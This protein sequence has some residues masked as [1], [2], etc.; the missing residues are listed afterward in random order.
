MFVYASAGGG[1]RRMNRHYFVSLP[2][3]GSR[4]RRGDRPCL[5]VPYLFPY[6]RKQVCPVILGMNPASHL[7]AGSE[8]PGGAG[9]GKRLFSGSKHMGFL[10]LPCVVN[11]RKLVLRW[12]ERV[13]CLTCARSTRA[14]WVWCMSELL[15]L[16]TRG[17]VRTLERLT[18]L[19]TRLSSS[20]S[21]RID[22]SD[23]NLPLD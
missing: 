3:I 15:S 18:G 17:L 21:V 23:W 12:S 6:G 7:G 10:R 20:V 11:W 22:L 1:G 13:L 8:V 16:Y 4:L 9:L 19:E 5:H 2:A 14:W